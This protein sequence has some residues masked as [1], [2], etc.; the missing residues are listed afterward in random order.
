MAV[1]N[2]V[3]PATLLCGTGRALTILCDNI[4]GGEVFQKAVS[5]SIIGGAAFQRAVPAS[6]DLC[7]TLR[8]ILLSLH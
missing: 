4:L 5:V 8:E 2:T 1:Y 7:R 3:R 6:D